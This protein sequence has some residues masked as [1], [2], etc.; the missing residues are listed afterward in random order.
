MFHGSCM[1]WDMYKEAIERLSGHFHVVIPALPGHDPET[2]EDYTSVEDI[3]RE[4]ED[5]LLGRRKDGSVYLYGLSML[6]P[7]SALCDAGAVAV[8]APA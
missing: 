6:P 5:W 1:F 2:T 7:T 3:A 4:M 8:E